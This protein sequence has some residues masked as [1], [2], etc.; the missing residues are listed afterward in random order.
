MAA[1]LLPSPAS[2]APGDITTV[3]GG[4][5]GDGGP[6]T[7]AALRAPVSVAV[8][9]A[10]N[11]FI[12]DLNS[13]TVRKV[14]PSGIITTVAGTGTQTFA[15]DGG[16]AVKA[17]FSSPSAVAVDGAG[18]LYIA[19]QVDGRI[20]RVAVNGIVTTIAGN[21]GSNPGPDGEL[22]TA[23]GLSSPVAL[24][25]D[26]SGNLIE[27]EGGGLVRKI[28]TH[29]IITTVAGGGSP[30]DGLGDHGPA[31]AAALNNPYGVA[32]DG[33]HNLWISD[34]GN[35]R[36]RKVDA[37][38]II[39]TA[40]GDGNFGFS[41]DGGPAVNAEIGQ[42]VGIAVDRAGN[43]YFADAN[44][45]IRRIDTAGIITTFAGRC[46]G[47]DSG[48]GG[49]AT[50]AQIFNPYGV[51]VDGSGNLYFTQAFAQ[52]F[53]QVR[54][55]DVHG[56]ITRIAGGG[57]GDGDPATSARLLAPV[58][59][60]Y[61]GAGLFI[62]EQYDNR[63]RRVDAHGVMSTV[64]GGGHP[65]DQLGD[66]GPATSAALNQPL[67]VALTPA[68]DTLLIADCGNRRVRRVG[69][70]GIITTVAGGG[71]PADGVGDNGPATSAHLG[72]PTGLLLVTSQL[73]P[74]GP[75]AGTLLIAD[76]RDNRVRSVDPSGAIT[77][78]AG[79]GN[80]GFNGDGNSA[81]FTDLNCPS[82][83]A[84]DPAGNLLIADTANNRVRSV[85]GRGNVTT[86]AG[87]GA[88]GY[89]T[90][91]GT[92]TGTHV[93]GPTG[94]AFEANGNLL[95]V[96]NYHARVRRVD[97]AGRITTVAGTGVPGFSGD[98][99]PA[100][101]ATIS[102]PS[103]VTVD[104]AGNIL[105]TDTGATDGPNNRVRRIQ[106][107]PATTP[108]PPQCG[109]VIVKNITLSADI[110]PCPSTVDGIV[111]GADNI[112]VNLN[113][114]RISGPG[115]GKGT[116][117][118]AG[119]RL[120]QRRGVNITGGGVR[121]FDA[122][123]ALVG[124]SGNTITNMTVRNNVA[125]LVT[126]NGFEGSEFGDGIVLMFSGGNRIAH[127][128]ITANGVFDNI[129]ILGLGSDNNTITANTI[130]NEVGDSLQ[131]TNGVGNGINISPFLDLTLPGR[132]NSLLANNI[133]G[134]TVSGNYTGGIASQS[135]LGATI[136]HNVIT[137]NGL[138]N[139]HPGNGIGIFHNQRAVPNLYDVVDSNVIH[140]NAGNGIDVFG[141]HNRFTN[142]NATGNALVN[143]R[144]F[145]LLDRG[146]T[147]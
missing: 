4:G 79:T 128:V 93:N 74:S 66:N 26:P 59:L 99:G 133:V 78:I 16:P 137:D 80:A 11:V 20:R 9:A 125:P 95:V 42:P 13:S 52:E 1:I 50:A 146:G 89:G 43:A 48:D 94:L 75:P 7:S 46:C 109:E 112:T 105:F 64:A 136:A 130:T 45:R 98:G 142:N 19:D 65:A 24:T 147:P 96:E 28:D 29:G 121:G 5:L 100:T 86:V 126:A 36:I 138:L 6:A 10:G 77:T 88:T 101:S 131:G 102:H 123:I 33:H 60:R 17:S 23:A 44:N 71:S 90:D 32:V 58:G 84:F 76:C 104:G 141:D 87:D 82:D 15:G 14:A 49:P 127:N 68:A 40:A 132:G 81:P 119:I 27:A 144:S 35:Q 129:G 62:S 139:P 30:A 51:A 72:C 57:L 73:N 37:N 85:D 135:N 3:A 110:G 122:G 63:V 117:S 97:T 103:Q 2:A 67:G 34:Q 140:G 61:T 111:I 91:G 107:G 120:T 21:G 145:D 53:S 38:G 18:R 124:S 115:P 69:P 54:K 108:K 70:D 106:P 25:F 92:A 22:A 114:H 113:G 8:D 143:P 83:L 56:I 118:H 41:G 12:A 47:G 39:T 134:N 116:G 31:T 55:V